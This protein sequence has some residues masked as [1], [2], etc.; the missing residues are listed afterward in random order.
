MIEKRNSNGKRI[1]ATRST[2]TRSRTKEGT[3]R[4]KQREKKRRQDLNQGLEEL[5]N[6]LAQTNPAL[7]ADREQFKAMLQLDPK[8]MQQTTGGKT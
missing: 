2:S 8:R 6:M 7:K 5:H 1:G 4:K 3:E